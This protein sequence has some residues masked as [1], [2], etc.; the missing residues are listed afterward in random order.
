MN[1]PSEL[2]QKRIDELYKEIIY[3]SIRDREITSRI[4][5]ELRGLLKAMRKNETNN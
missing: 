2:V 1:K 5:R 4:I 3:Q